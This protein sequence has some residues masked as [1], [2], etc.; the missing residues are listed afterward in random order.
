M[1]RVCCAR[2]KVEREKPGIIDRFFSK[3]LPLE[4]YLDF[5]LIFF[6]LIFLNFNICPEVD[7]RFTL[8]RVSLSFSQT[9]KKKRLSI[10]CLVFIAFPGDIVDLIFVP[11]FLFCPHCHQS[12]VL[13]LSSQISLLNLSSRHGYSLSPG[14][15][16]NSAS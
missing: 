12:L 1:S 16:S 11:I 6:L 4:D 9:H 7:R 8:V 14:D 2:L 3:L 15:G 5:F 13:H 10:Q